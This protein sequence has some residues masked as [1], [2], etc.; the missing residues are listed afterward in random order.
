VHRWSQPEVADTFL[1]AQHYVETISFTRRVK[2]ILH[3]LPDWMSNLGISILT[4]S[5]TQSGFYS[6]SFNT[7]MSC[8]IYINIRVVLYMKVNQ[9]L[10]TCTCIYE[11]VF[12]YSITEYI[13]LFSVTGQR[14]SWWPFDLCVTC[15]TYHLNIFF[16]E[17]QSSIDTFLYLFC[18]KNINY[19]WNVLLHTFN[20]FI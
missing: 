11:I 16:W 14:I 4:F 2:V 12:D 6:I 19:H 20:E 8:N 13:T 9:L 7:V 15:M 17:I 5:G 10:D 3:W 1:L 18:L